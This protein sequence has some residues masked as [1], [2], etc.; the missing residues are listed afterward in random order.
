M[1]KDAWE[2][3]SRLIGFGLRARTVTVGVQQV[4]VA[5]QK[6][7]V[8]LAIV[9]DDAS[10]NGKAKVVPMMKARRVE[11]VGGVTAADLGSV[12][13]RDATTVVAVLDAALARGMREAMASPTA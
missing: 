4:K 8:V 2:K 13:G 6:N 1:T 10:E 5:V 7:L 9:A 11:M 3:V 12:V